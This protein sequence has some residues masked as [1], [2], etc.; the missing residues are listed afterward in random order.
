M[1]DGKLT[2]THSAV[3]SPKSVVENEWKKWKLSDLWSLLKHKRMVSTGA[4]NAHAEQITKALFHEIAKTVI[5][6]QAQP[7]FV[8]MPIAGEITNSD[9]AEPYEQILYEFCDSLEGTICWSMKEH[10]KKKIEAGYSYKWGHWDSPGHKTIA[11]YLG[12]NLIESK[13][14]ESKTQEP[15]TETSG[16]SN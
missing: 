1:E 8:Y 14:V 10:F 6:I 12:R 9:V 7:L 2:L 4:Y 16:S 11:E 3:P 15:L 5:S 13:L